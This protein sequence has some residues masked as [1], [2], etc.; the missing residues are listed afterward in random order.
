MPIEVMERYKVA[1][2]NN[3]DYISIDDLFGNLT[4]NSGEPGVL[5]KG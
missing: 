2:E 3:T 1:T 4:K 5:L